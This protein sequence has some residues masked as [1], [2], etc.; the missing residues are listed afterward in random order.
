MAALVKRKTTGSAASL[1]GVTGIMVFTNP[2]V[3]YLA[4]L[5]ASYFCSQVYA[6]KYLLVVNS[7]SPVT[8][9]LEKLDEYNATRLRE[10]VALEDLGVPT[11]RTQPMVIPR[12][13]YPG[14]VEV[15]MPV[16]DRD[17]WARVVAMI[18]T[19]FVTFVSHDAIWHPLR[20]L[21][22][23]AFLDEHPVIL[24]AEIRY[25]IASQRLA[26]V[27]PTAGLPDT[28]IVS[29]RHFERVEL[30]K[31]KIMVPATRHTRM[32]SLRILPTAG[33]DKEEEFFR[34][35]VSSPTPSEVGYAQ[36]V[37]TKVYSR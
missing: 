34:D 5:A 26:I 10:G 32:L 35:I 1:P 12:E 16:L 9:P 14:A 22:Q 36:E 28:A 8:V 18:S 27:G 25:G 37:L 7:T 24:S 19:D 21:S 29:R 13:G 17:N 4:R 6:N 31:R 2:S 30:P 3:W 20:L 11:V 33:V 23:A 15:F